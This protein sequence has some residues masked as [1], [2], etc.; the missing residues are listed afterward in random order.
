MDRGVAPSLIQDLC[1]SAIKK[2]RYASKS[3]SDERSN[4]FVQACVDNE[5]D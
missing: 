2:N 1:V 3:E 4:D 5:M